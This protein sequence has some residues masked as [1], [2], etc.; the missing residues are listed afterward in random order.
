MGPGQGLHGTAVIFSE[1][2]VLITGTSGSG[3][4]ALALALLALAKATRRFAAL[5]GDD[6]V[7]VRAAEGRIVAFG[8]PQLAGLIERRAAGV[9]SAPSEPAAVVSLVVALSGRNHSWPR[10]PDEPDACVVEGITLPRLALN[11]AVS[12]V[13]SAISVDERLTL[14]SSRRAG[15]NGNSLEQCN[16][17]HKNRLVA[18]SSTAS[19]TPKAMAGVMDIR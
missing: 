18:A 17:V 7:W 4:S 15:R 5:V 19:A 9:Q 16:A 11:S 2:C 8:A 1:S 6:R 12:A 14:I 3:K 10:W 13:D